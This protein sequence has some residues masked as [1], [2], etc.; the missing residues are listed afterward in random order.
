MV[1]EKWDSYP[2][3]LSIVDHIILHTYVTFDYLTKKSRAME[4]HHAGFK[5]LTSLKIS[6]PDSTRQQVFHGVTLF[7]EL[8]D[9]DVDFPLAE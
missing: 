6:Q 2:T 9:R 4:I 7:L 8:M 3:T 1:G 5:W